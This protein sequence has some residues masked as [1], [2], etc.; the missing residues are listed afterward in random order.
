MGTPKTLIGAI[1]N[2]LRLHQLGTHAGV[3]QAV[4]IALHVQDHLNQRLGV[5]AL[6]RRRG[7]ADAAVAL[8]EMLATD[9]I[10]PQMPPRHRK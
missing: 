5:L 4:L 8:S 7:M 3:P 6:S 2:A 1:E 9:A 10:A